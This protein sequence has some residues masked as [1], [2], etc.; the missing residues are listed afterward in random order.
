MSASAQGCPRLRAQGSERFE[1]TA[2]ARVWD[3]RGL[4]A[5]STPS[6]PLPDP[7]RLGRA[8]ANTRLLARGRGA[9]PRLPAEREW[10]RATGS[11]PASSWPPRSTSTSRTRPAIRSRR[12]T[13]AVHAAAARAARV[14]RRAR[15]GGGGGVRDAASCSARPAARRARSRSR[16]DRHR[17]TALALCASWTV[18]ALLRRVVPGGAPRGLRA[19]GARAAAGDRAAGRACSASGGADHAAALRAPVSRSGSGSPTT[20]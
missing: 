6:Q 5:M 20:T 10:R 7:T 12:S 8:G 1:L 17:G 3:N 13:E 16:R 2:R 4:R 14:P 9:A 19:A 15:A 11:T 18:G